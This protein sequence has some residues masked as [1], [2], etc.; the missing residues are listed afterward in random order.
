MKNNSIYALP[1]E[2]RKQ[3]YVLATYYIVLDKETDVIGKRKRWLS[4]RQ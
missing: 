1:E 3:N 2:I 4:V